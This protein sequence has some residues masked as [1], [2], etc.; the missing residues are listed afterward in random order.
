MASALSPQDWPKAVTIGRFEDGPGSENRTPSAQDYR[1]KIEPVIAWE[2][3]FFSHIRM[4][5]LSGH[6]VLFIQATR[7]SKDLLLT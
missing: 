7:L 4:A 2:T 3:R 1:E 6:R 5:G